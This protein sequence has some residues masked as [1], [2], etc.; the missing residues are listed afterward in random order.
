MENAEIVRSF[1][2]A[3][4]KGEYELILA[5]MSDGVNW[6][7]WAENS[8]QKAGVPWLLPRKGPEE[9]AK[10]FETLAQMKFHEFEVI[11]MIEGGNQVAV[12]VR[13]DMEL[14]N[15][16][17]IR[18]EEIHLW[19]LAGVGKVVRFRHYVDTH[20]HIEAAGSLINRAT[21]G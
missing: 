21:A 19:T 4:R 2:E 7:D 17:R 14:P 8:A 13:L 15:G 3:F 16:T 1:Y 12:E 10:F 20:K 18:D 6:E 11:S 9:V 5:E